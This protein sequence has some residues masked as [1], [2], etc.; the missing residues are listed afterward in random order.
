MSVGIDLPGFEPTREYTSTILSSASDIARLDDDVNRLMPDRDV[1]LSPQFALASVDASWSPRV[2]V[3]S[4]RSAVAGVVFGKERWVAGVPT[5]V[6]YA[7]GRLGHLTVSNGDDCEAILLT[8]IRSWFAMPRIRGVRLAIAPSSPEAN[9]IERTAA[10]MRLDVTRAT[11][12]EYEM[13]SALP[14]PSSYEA[15]VTSLGAQ[16]RHNFRYY[17]RRF[18]AAGH[19]FVENL[20]PREVEEILLQLRMKSQI[21]FSA[22]RMRTAARR[23][24]STDQPWAA[25]LRHANGDYLSVTAGWFD[26][27]RAILLL[28]QNNDIEF[29]QA[30]LSV[31]LRGY[32]IETLIAR[33]VPEL[34]IWSGAA[35]PLSRYVKPLP[36]I[37]VYFDARTFGWRMIRRMVGG[38]QRFAGRRVSSEL[39][40]VA[41]P[42]TN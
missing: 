28:Q 38:M 13:H 18:E 31:V 15:F 35:A 8:A 9:V 26:R 5:G 12:A 37:S 40:W 14:L 23:V 29:S 41:L 1:S 7:D 27:G 39:R 20:P 4:R 17:R 32:L 16:T 33:R 36:A 2:A 6:I 11:P 25:A 42:G 22:A 3:V 24:M 19:R 30:S 34:L 10:T 21:P